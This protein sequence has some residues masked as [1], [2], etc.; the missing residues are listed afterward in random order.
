MIKRGYGVR[1]A[2][3]VAL[4]ILAS[5]GA[6]NSITGLND[7]VFYGDPNGG[8]V[9]GSSASAAAG[10][11]GGGGGPASSSG[12]S[13][14]GGSCTSPAGVCLCDWVTPQSNA[15]PCGGC[16]KACALGNICEKGACQCPQGMTDCTG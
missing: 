14:T 2:G 7:I 4:L 11:G 3:T 13:G 5:I 15:H 9:D 12:G 8:A 16:E 1:A 10:G 6:C